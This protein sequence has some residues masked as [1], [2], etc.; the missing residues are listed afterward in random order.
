MGLAGTSIKQFPNWR[1]ID[2]NFCISFPVPWWKIYVG[3][4]GRKNHSFECSDPPMQ[5]CIRRSSGFKNI[6]NM[7]RYPKSNPLGTQRKCHFGYVLWVWKLHNSY[8]IPFVLSTAKTTSSQALLHHAVCQLLILVQL[9]RFSNGPFWLMFCIN[10]MVQCPTSTTHVCKSK[11]NVVFC[12]FLEATPNGDLPILR[13]T[14]LL[15][16]LA[17]APFNSLRVFFA[18]G[19]KSSQNTMAQTENANSL[20]SLV[21]FFSPKPSR[22]WYKVQYTLVV[23]HDTETF[24]KLVRWL[25]H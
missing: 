14:A 22:D 20:D 7:I 10:G 12:L 19:G 9:L 24:T 1:I 18:L 15:A 13:F 23:K 11:W 8:N 3:E 16:W 2:R 17:S 4:T 21:S 6:W 25:Q 5:R